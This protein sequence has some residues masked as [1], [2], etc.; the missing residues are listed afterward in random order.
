MTE[1]VDSPTAFWADPSR[2]ADPSGDAAAERSLDILNAVGDGFY[3][4]DAE[5]R[6]SASTTASWR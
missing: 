4:L 5:D 3:R 1:S 6:S 2:W